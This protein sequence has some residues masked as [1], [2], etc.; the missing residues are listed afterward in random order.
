MTDKCTSPT[1]GFEI[2]DCPVEVSRA[3]IKC[4]MPLLSI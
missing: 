1:D 4:V 3:W 2:V